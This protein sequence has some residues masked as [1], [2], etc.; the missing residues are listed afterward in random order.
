MKK[1]LLIISL[2]FLGACSQ[3]GIVESSEYIDLPSVSV[4]GNNTSVQ[5][6]PGVS[7]RITNMYV[8]Y[9]YLYF[10]I[11]N[12]SYRNLPSFYADY[13]LSCG[14]S[15]YRTGNLYFSS[16]W[17]YESES[18]SIYAGYNATSCKLTITAIYSGDSGLMTWQGSYPVWTW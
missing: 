14:Y 16:L 9:S 5:V 2:F 4:P 7:F 17:E 12:I 3:S 6:V 11:E 1:I 10:E 13:E 15:L 18:Y 8:N